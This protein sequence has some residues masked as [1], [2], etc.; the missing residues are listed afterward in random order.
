MIVAAQPLSDYPWF[1]RLFFCKQQR[2]YGRILDPGCSGP[3]IM[4]VS[5]RGAVVLICVK[6]GDERLS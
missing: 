4:G 3:F 5:Q 2:T 6:D 1:I